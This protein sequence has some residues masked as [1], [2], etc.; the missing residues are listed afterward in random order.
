M[1]LEFLEAEIFNLK[2]MFYLE[3]NQRGVGISC[4]QTC[5]GGDVGQVEL[6][7]LEQTLVEGVVLVRAV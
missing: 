7:Y 4:S 6:P 3:E 1:K 2:R 5:P